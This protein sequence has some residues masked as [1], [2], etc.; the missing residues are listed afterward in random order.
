MQDCLNIFKVIMEKMNRLM[1]NI[2][3]FNGKQTVLHSTEQDRN[4]KKKMAEDN[5]FVEVTSNIVFQMA[6]YNF[7]LDNRI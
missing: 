1:K 4:S 5:N 3:S 6:G 7:F 2:N